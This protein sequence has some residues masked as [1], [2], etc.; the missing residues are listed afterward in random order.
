M[1]HYVARPDHLAL[2]LAIIGDPVD[3]IKGV[4]GWGLAKWKALAKNL[5]NEMDV[6]IAAKALIL[7]MNKFQ[8]DEFQASFQRT[9]LKRNV[10]GVPPPARLQLASPAKVRALGIPGINTLYAQVWEAYETKN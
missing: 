10:P 3:N 2:A 5:T 4:R 9:L 1:K 7:K 8:E 6:D